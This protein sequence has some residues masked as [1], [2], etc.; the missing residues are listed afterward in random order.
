MDTQDNVSHVR[1]LVYWLNG[2]LPPHPTG[3]PQ[4]DVYIKSLATVNVTSSG[5]SIFI[6]ELK[7]NMT[8]YTE[9]LCTCIWFHA[10]KQLLLDFQN[11]SVH[12]FPDVGDGQGTKVE[13]LSS[14]E[15]I[16]AL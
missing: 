10:S 13:P 5:K 8:G 11:D 6:D 12:D 7:R 2:T 4:F 3:T 1:R 14:L 15:R 9:L 16:P